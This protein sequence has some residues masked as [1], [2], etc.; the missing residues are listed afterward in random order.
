MFNYMFT[1]PCDPNF[2]N[3][4][5]ILVGES[6]WRYNPATSSCEEVEYKCEGSLGTPPNLYLSQAACTAACVTSKSC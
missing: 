6:R 2:V 3:N 1:D 4:C 5:A